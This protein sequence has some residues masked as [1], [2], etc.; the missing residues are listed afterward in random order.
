MAAARESR[1]VMGVSES[2]LEVKSVVA[3]P[4]DTASDTHS[5]SNWLGRMRSASLSNP[6][7]SGTSS[8]GMYNFPLSPITGSSTFCS[9]RKLLSETTRA[10]WYLH[11]T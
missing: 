3:H 1:S 7:Y 5:A 6:L 11:P 9:Q 8:S 10:L 4:N 2:S